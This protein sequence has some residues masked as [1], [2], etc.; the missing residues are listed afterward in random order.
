MYEDREDTETLQSQLQAKDE[1]IKQCKETLEW[2]LNQWSIDGIPVSK[3]GQCVQ[4][5]LNL[6]KEAKNG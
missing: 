6:I 2:I 4:S 5:T 3:Y 1:L